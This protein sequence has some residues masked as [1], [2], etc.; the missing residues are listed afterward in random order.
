MRI[1]PADEERPGLDLCAEFICVQ[2][3][4]LID[5]RPQCDCR[6]SWWIRFIMLWSLGMSY[7]RTASSVDKLSLM[8]S[9]MRF[10]SFAMGPKRTIA[11]LTACRD[12]LLLVKG[13]AFIITRSFEPTENVHKSKENTSSLE[14]FYHFP[15][16]IH[17]HHIPAT[18]LHSPS[19]LPN[20]TISCSTGHSSRKVLDILA[21]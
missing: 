5:I 4:I 19:T 15:E 11:M 17:P 12:V 2:V 14:I 8:F 20:L 1:D 21:K 13:H 9:R 6:L 16:R 18:C 10:G 7:Y 3:A